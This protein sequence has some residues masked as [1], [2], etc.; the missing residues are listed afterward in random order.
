[1]LAADTSLSVVLVRWLNMFLVV[2]YI[3]SAFVEY[4]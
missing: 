2:A 3:F 4:T 1:M